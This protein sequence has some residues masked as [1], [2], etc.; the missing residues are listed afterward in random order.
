MQFAAR[1][2]S[3]CV[4]G[5]GVESQTFTSLCFSTQSS[6][7][8]SS[9]LINKTRI[10]HQL[11]WVVAV[12]WYF[13]CLTLNLSKLSLN[14]HWSTYANFQSPHKHTIKNP[15]PRLR[16]H[17]NTSQAISKT[18]SMRAHKY[19]HT[20]SCASKHNPACVRLPAEV[21]LGLVWQDD[22][23]DRPSAE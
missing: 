23:T 21:F 13:R 16:P 4:W 19:T 12:Y 9:C 2:D 10:I 8:K 6:F 15:R 17:A 14:F 5:E 22:C 7:H 1:W 3:R 18:T 20:N 11:H